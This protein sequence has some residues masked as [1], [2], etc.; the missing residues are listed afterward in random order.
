[1]SILTRP[2]DVF[3]L[4]PCQAHPSQ[5]AILSAEAFADLDIFGRGHAIINEWFRAWIEPA[6]Q[7]IQAPVRG[8]AVTFQRTAELLNFMQHFLQFRTVALRQLA[9]TQAD[10]DHFRAREAAL[11]DQ[12]GSY[13]AVFYH[14]LE[15]ATLPIPSALDRTAKRSLKTQTEYRNSLV[16]EWFFDVGLDLDATKGVFDRD[17]F[18]DL[19]RK[20]SRHYS[21]DRTVGGWD[22]RRFWFIFSTGLT[23]FITMGEKYWNYL[24]G[25]DGWTSR[26]TLFNRAL[27][28][29]GPLDAV[30]PSLRCIHDPITLGGAFA[31]GAAVSAFFAMS[32]PGLFGNLPFNW[33]DEGDLCPSE[34]VTGILWRLFSLQS[35]ERIFQSYTRISHYEAALDAA[36][37]GNKRSENWHACPTPR[38]FLFGFPAHLITHRSTMSYNLVQPVAAFCTLPMQ[39]HP[40]VPVALDAAASA[41]VM[42]AWKPALRYRA[43][44]ALKPSGK[45]S[46]VVYSPTNTIYCLIAAKTH[47]NFITAARDFLLP[48]VDG[49]HY[50]PADRANL[51]RFADIVLYFADCAGI[52]WEMAFNNGETWTDG[53]ETALE[54]S[55]YFKDYVSGRWAEDIE[56][57]F[58]ARGLDARAVQGALTA[59][60]PAG[61]DSQ[62]YQDIFYSGVVRAL[63]SPQPEYKHIQNHPYTHTRFTFFSALLR[64]SSSNLRSA[65]LQRIRDPVTLGG[66]FGARAPYRSTNIDANTR[67]NYLMRDVTA[68]IR[69][70]L[71]DLPQ[72]LGA[73]LPEPSE[74]RAEQA[75]ATYLGMPRL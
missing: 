62:L 27:M 6:V 8:D 67:A 35:D 2:E 13:W 9:M 42:D 55:Q 15:R 65:A 4:F 58:R 7:D 68:I 63:R 18:Q 41:A 53:G 25:F 70:A 47:E 75:I 39:P 23:K 26:F 30:I 5:S 38:E 33:A 61:Q 50:T 48:R 73:T 66:A 1:M 57:F 21:T 59:C 51:S 43:D 64:D 11:L 34:R 74:R 71:E 31:V 44:F 3:S 28:H 37:S 69:Y 19:K 17:A 40:T 20:V 24:V 54:T 10:I 46:P 14:L 60:V 72:P 56:R 12:L 29:E 36:R 32:R 16:A 52:Y 22:K 45:L 49:R